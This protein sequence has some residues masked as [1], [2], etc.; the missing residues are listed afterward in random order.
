MPL[1]AYTSYIPSVLSL[2]KL[3]L[4]VMI[5]TTLG[6]LAVL[7]SNNQHIMERYTTAHFVHLAAVG[8]WLLLQFSLKHHSSSS[9][10]CSY[11]WKRA[12]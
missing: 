1:G 12:V 2:Q 5:I 3:H 6:I 10:L 8:S 11:S 7:V 9:C 4:S